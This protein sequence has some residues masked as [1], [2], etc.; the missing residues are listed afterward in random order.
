MGLGSQM[1][2]SKFGVVLNPELDV[3]LSFS[4]LIVHDAADPVDFLIL[5]AIG[6]RNLLNLKSKRLRG[7]LEISD[8]R[9]T[10]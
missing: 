7:S 8:L 3:L 1:F 10:H 6:I 5:F 4:L 9:N 2:H